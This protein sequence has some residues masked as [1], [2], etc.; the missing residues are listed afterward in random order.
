MNQTGKNVAHLVMNQTGRTPDLWIVAR[1]ERV[2][3]TKWKEK[4]LKLSA[5]N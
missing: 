5:L 2:G 4:R 3:R 1:E